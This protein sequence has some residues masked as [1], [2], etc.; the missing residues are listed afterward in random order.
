MDN[1]IETLRTE[2]EVSMER[3]ACSEAIQAYYKVRLHIP[4]S[5]NTSAGFWE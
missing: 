1:L 5:N 3:F 4:I 2:T